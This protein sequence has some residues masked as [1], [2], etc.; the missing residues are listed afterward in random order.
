MTDQKKAPF[1]GKAK[2]ISPE[3]IALKTKYSFTLNPND[4][5]QY[6]DCTDRIEKLTEFMEHE[7]LEI[8]NVDIDMHM[9][10]SR[11]G[12]LHFHGTISFNTID[13][14]KHFYVV[15]MHPWQQFCNLV[16]E[17]ITDKDKWEEYCK[18]S[19]KI[20]DVNITTKKCFDKYRK[21]K[22]DKNGVAHKSFF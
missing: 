15:K 9:E 19:K 13:S 7:L 22:V 5:R 18:K 4:K 2:I 20:I 6:F 14:I 16:I 3:D 11:N 8:P 17:T 21:V 1:I 12:R 10:I